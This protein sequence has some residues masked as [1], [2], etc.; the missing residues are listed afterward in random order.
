MY[1]RWE[2]LRASDKAGYRFEDCT[3]EEFPDINP[4]IYLEKLN[5]FNIDDLEIDEEIKDIIDYRILNM[6][7]IVKSSLE[8]LVEY[9]S[10]PK[11]YSFL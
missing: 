8:I 11:L 1:R 4:Y 5:N 3:R 9:F 6:L 2:L 10:N 7:S